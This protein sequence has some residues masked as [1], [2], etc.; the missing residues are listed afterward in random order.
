[1]LVQG[2]AGLR[3]PT[4]RLGAVIK[5]ALR[6]DPAIGLKKLTKHV[7]QEGGLPEGARTCLRNTKVFSWPCRRTDLLPLQNS[8]Q[9]RVTRAIVAAGIA[10]LCCPALAPATT[11]EVRAVLNAIQ[12][13]AP[14]PGACEYNRSCAHHICR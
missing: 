7:Q 1:M 4:G 14:A 11:K 10:A 6:C 12:E 2:A 9:A 3:R 5:A 13:M 8:L